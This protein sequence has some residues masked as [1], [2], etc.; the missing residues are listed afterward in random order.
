MFYDFGQRVVVAR[1]VIQFGSGFGINA[2]KA[3]LRDRGRHAI[4]FRKNDV[5]S[6]RDRAKLGDLGN[7]VCDRGT[8]PWPLPDRFQA[9]L[10]DI[11]DNDR[12]NL[13]WPRPEH[14]KEIKGADAQFLQRPRISEPQ[15]H[16]R[17]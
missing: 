10:I 17:E 9:R 7:E 15:R 2:A 12:P 5:E 6:D 11:N 4:G 16:Q 3:S 14:L 13:L 1:Q 8:R